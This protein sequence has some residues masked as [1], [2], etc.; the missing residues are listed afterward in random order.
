[1]TE[2]LGAFGDGDFEQLVR[3]T[4][5]HLWERDGRPP[6]GEKHYWYKALEKC[7]RRYADKERTRR[8]L[9]D[10]M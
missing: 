7:M 9:V 4:A 5:Y 8:G 10:P 6:D 2:D 3:V 1:M